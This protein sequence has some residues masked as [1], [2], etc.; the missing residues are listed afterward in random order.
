MSDLKEIFSIYNDA[1]LDV[2]LN[3]HKWWM[4]QPLSILLFQWLVLA[5]ED[6]FEKSIY[7]KSVYMSTMTFLKENIRS[8]LK[9]DLHKMLLRE[10][11]IKLQSLRCNF[12][13]AEIL[14]RYLVFMLWEIPVITLSILF[15]YQY[16]VN[17]CIS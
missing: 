1:V 10:F 11:P 12:I 2:S 6:Q 4:F 15:L 7:G 3:F 14:W 17:I 9:K 8:Y 13:T 5:N 16:F